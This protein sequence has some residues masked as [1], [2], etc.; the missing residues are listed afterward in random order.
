MRLL[1]SKAE[2]LQQGEGLDGLYKHIELCGRTCYKSTDKMTEDSAKPFVDRMIASH[3][4]AMLEFGTVYLKMSSR[5]GGSKYKDNKYSKAIFNTKDK[6]WYITTNL[7][8]LVENDWLK[9]LR[10]L[11]TPTELHE[12]RYTIRFT[13]ARII[14]QMNMR[15]RVFSFAQESQRYCNYT[16]EDKDLMF[17]K[18][19]NLALNLGEYTIVGN[20]KSLGDVV[21]DGYIKPLSDRSAENLFILSC[22][23]AED[24]YEDLIQKEGWQPQQ[25]RQ[26]LPNCTKTEFCM[27][28]FASDWRY[29]FDL[30]LFEKTGKADP[31]EKALAEKAKNT[32]LDTKVWDNVMSCSSRFPENKKK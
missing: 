3:H 24:A 1:E 19:T 14:S 10:Y 29:Y 32:M 11:C 18:P 23:F 12:K 16:K 27:T 28:G 25:A 20:E 21:G 17:I 30:R 5:A 31:E 2:L 26:I 13:C 15:H 8:V 22:L 9:D 7:R 4:T 6:G